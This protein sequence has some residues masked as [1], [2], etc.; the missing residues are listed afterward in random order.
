MTK[1]LFFRKTVLRADSFKRPLILKSY[2]DYKS[3]MK[4]NRFNDLLLTNW[5]LDVRN[6]F[7]TIFH[8]E[9]QM[10]LLKQLQV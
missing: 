7:K 5:S 4:H 10:I 3:T 1:I 6:F 9:I 2:A 8:P